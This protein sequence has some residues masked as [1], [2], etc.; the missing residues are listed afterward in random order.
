MN[1]GN[2]A[3]NGDGARGEREGRDEEGGKEKGR[4][5]GRKRKG[6]TRPTAT[7]R[8][9]AVR[10]VGMTYAWEPQRFRMSTLRIPAAAAAFIQ[11]VEDKRA[12]FCIPFAAVIQSFPSLRVA[13]VRFF[14]IFAL[15]ISASVRP[16][17][18]VVG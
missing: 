17:A 12:H 9:V 13:S 7:D 14:F 16:S 2:E 3:K 18:S 5:E 6:F 10:P 15:F 11:V 8:V 4:K 1:G